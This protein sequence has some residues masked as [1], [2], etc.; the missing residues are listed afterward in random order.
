MELPLA[1]RAPVMDRVQPIVDML[2]RDV[3][4]SWIPIPF[5]IVVT[6][7]CREILSPQ[8]FQDF[9]RDVTLVYLKLPI[10]RTLAEAATRLFGVK[11]QSILRWAPRA[12]DAMFRSCGTLT[13]EPT[14]TERESR[15]LLDR[16]PRDEFASGSFVAALA[17]S[18]HAAF[19]VTH[20]TGRIEIVSVNPATGTARFLA[21]DG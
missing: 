4:V 5:D 21:R 2:E 20:S 11:A 14:S 8:Q 10:L 3:S 1:T 19:A 18:F 13:Y 12:W 7:A 6:D 15:L 16:F 9:W 17:A